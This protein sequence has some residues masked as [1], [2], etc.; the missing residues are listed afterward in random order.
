[1][2]AV[3]IRHEVANYA[4]WKRV[5]HAFRGFRKASG[6]KNFRVFR[7]SSSPNDLTV[8]CGW[9]T[10]ARMRKFLKSAELRKAMKEA[11]VVSKPVVQLF[12]KMEDLSVG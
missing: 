11:G 6:E 10:S 12:S 2:S 5:V 9:A 3:L 1:M 7:S 4:R 8:I